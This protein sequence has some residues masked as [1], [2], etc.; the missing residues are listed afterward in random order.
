MFSKICNAIQIDG[1][2]PCSLIC[3]ERRKSNTIIEHPP[4]CQSPNLFAI[5]TVHYVSVAEI[6][7]KI[8]GRDERVIR[9]AA[10]R[11]V[12]VHCHVEGRAPWR[13]W[14]EVSVGHICAVATTVH[15]NLINS[16]RIELN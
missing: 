10:S 4:I 12:L 1:M 14:A 7:R 8:V 15:A 3:T 9:L 2:Q 16:S 5:A 6:T 11:A 13:S